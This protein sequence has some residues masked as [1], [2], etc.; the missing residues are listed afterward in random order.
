MQKAE[1]PNCG[2]QISNCRLRKPKRG[3]GGCARPLGAAQNRPISDCRL[4][5]SDWGTEQL[6]I[7]ECGMRIAEKM[8]AG[9]QERSF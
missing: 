2:L 7:A 9:T 3:G 5:I 8:N 4:Q 1:P 6:R